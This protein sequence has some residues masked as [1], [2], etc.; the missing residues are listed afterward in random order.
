MI[1]VMQQPSAACAAC[2]TYYNQLPYYGP[3]VHNADCPVRLEEVERQRRRDHHDV[4]CLVLGKF[5]RGMDAGEFVALAHHVA[6]LAY[7][8]PKDEP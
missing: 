4:L 3:R 5:E 7:P 6:D 8:P 2:S 1:N